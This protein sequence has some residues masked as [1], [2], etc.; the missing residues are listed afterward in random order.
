[1]EQSDNSSSHVSSLTQFL[2]KTLHT[3]L[4]EVKIPRTYA[5]LNNLVD[6]INLNKSVYLKKRSAMLCTIRPLFVLS[7]I[8]D[9]L[10]PNARKIRT[11]ISELELFTYL[12]RK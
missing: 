3:I 10:Q 8:S 4:L 11:L 7:L 6:G 12:F 2:Y 1:M 9:A 5:V